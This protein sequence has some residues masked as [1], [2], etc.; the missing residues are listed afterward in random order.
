M[1]F[2]NP[3]PEMPPEIMDAAMTNPDAFAEAMGSGME[4]F[5][6][7]WVIAAIW[8]PHLKPWAM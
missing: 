4:P 7:Q 5:R 2:P 6:M 1:M 3:M 8:V